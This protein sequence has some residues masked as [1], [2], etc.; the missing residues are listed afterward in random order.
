MLVCFFCFFLT[1]V[2]PIHIWGSINH[3]KLKYL[4]KVHVIW[5]DTLMQRECECVLQYVWY[6]TAEGEAKCFT[7]VNKEY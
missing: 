1:V 6:C 4:I 5:M 2:F 3:I 7:G